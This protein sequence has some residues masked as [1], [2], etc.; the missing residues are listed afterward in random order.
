MTL[1]NIQH[2]NDG[3]KSIEIYEQI[4]R[5]HNSPVCW[6]S[7]TLDQGVDGL[8]NDL[9]EAFYFSMQPWQEYRTV[10]GE[11]ALG[12]FYSWQEYMFPPDIYDQAIY[13]FSELITTSRFSVNSEPV[14]YDL[15]QVHPTN[16]RITTRHVVSL[17]VMVCIYDA[18]SDLDCIERWLDDDTLPFRAGKSF[19]WLVENDA[20][21]LD[22]ILLF[23]YEKPEDREPFY[24]R[25]KD[26]REY[27][28]NADLWLSHLATLDLI[29]REDDLKS[30]IKKSE[31]SK[32]NTKSAK[33]PR[34]AETQKITLE[35][36]ASRWNNRHPETKFES[37]IDDLSKEFNV[38]ERTVSR[39]YSEAKKNNLV[40]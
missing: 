2:I 37:F 18:L 23:V 1:E 22:Q 36:V 33:K 38:S 31:I 17:A 32:I 25:I 29:K 16:E 3:R 13:R 10:P 4:E 30:A 34:K 26:A 5:L 15:E 39:R 40:S 12:D 28:K 8:L 24:K 35:L 20:D 27:L 7:V 9:E 6:S 14:L 21:Q 19:S 11:S